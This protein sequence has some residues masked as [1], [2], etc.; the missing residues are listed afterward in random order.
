MPSMTLVILQR[1]LGAAIGD[2]G[3]ADHA[4]PP[5]SHLAVGIERGF[6]LMTGHRPHLPR[7]DVL[8]AR[9]DQFYGPLHRFRQRQH[10][11]KHVGGAAPA[12]AAA[13]IELIELDLVRRGF[14]HRR[15]GEG[16]DA[17]ALGTDPDFG[18][19]A[20]RTDRRGGIHRLHLCVID[21]FG[22]V[23]RGHHLGGLGEGFVGVAFG[24][25]AHALVVEL[26]RVGEKL[27]QAGSAVERIGRHARPAHL[28]CRPPLEGGFDGLGDDADRILQRHDFEHAGHFQRRGVIDMLRRSAFDRR[29]QHRGVDHVRHLHVDGV[30]RR[31]VDLSRN[32]QARRIFAEDAVVGHFLQRRLV[33]R[34]HGRRHLGEARDLAIAHGAIARRVHHQA[35]PGVQF[36]DRNLPAIGGRLHQHIAHRGGLQ[37]HLVPIA[38]DRAAAIGHH[39]AAKN[40]IAENLRLHGWIRDRHPRP[41]G[42]H[43]FGENHGEPGRRALPHFGNRNGEHDG[44]VRTDGD[45]GA[46]GARRCAFRQR[47]GRPHE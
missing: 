8:L 3:F 15:G 13:E 7:F 26:A 1:L 24:D 9:P 30:K 37:P 14:E 10:F 28:Q 2:H 17:D 43:L 38:A 27:F 29:A 32:I 41:V 39:H 40:R 20:R 18:A 16:I 21:V 19:V 33:D 36:G 35:R 11:R 22:R 44:A 5:A 34:R 6:D 23:L 31:A 45:P 46:D 12:I 47:R 25:V 42:I 4:M